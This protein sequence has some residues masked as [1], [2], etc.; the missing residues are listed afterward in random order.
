MRVCLCVCAFVC[1]PPRLLITSGVIWTPYD[2]LNNFYSF[3]MATAVV[4]GSR[5]GLRIEARGGN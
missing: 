2:W 1:L 5:C 3:H 4:I